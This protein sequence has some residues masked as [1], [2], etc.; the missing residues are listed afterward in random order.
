MYR[1]VG[2]SVCVCMCVCVCMYVCVCFRVCV[3]VCVCVCVCV[4]MCVC[5]C[6]CMSVCVCAIFHLKPAEI[7]RGPGAGRE[8]LSWLYRLRC[9]EEVL[10]ILVDFLCRFISC[11]Y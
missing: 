4:C 6:V 3:Y 9:R 10:S 11:V 8:I 1:F 2:V 7:I 5:V